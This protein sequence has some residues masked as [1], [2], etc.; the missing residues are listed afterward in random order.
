MVDSYRTLSV[1]SSGVA[2]PA[3]WLEPPASE[4]TVRWIELGHAC[5]YG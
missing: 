5:S 1:A 3:P 4:P 2:L